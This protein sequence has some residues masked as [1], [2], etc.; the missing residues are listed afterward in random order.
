MPL[1]KTVTLRTPYRP[2][3]VTS[4]SPIV[5]RERVKQGDQASHTSKPSGVFAAAVF[6]LCPL[7][8]FSWRERNPPGAPPRRWRLSG[9]DSIKTPTARSTVCA[10]ARNASKRLQ[11]E[12]LERAKIVEGLAAGTPASVAASVITETGA[13]AEARG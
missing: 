4:I 12:Y 10:V 9:T 3:N 1:D 13:N 7:R 2:A 5:S 6:G 11:G 8:C